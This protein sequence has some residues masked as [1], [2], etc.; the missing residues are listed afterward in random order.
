MQMKTKNYLRFFQLST[1]ALLLGVSSQLW[2][3]NVTSEV[4]VGK[5]KVELFRNGKKVVPATVFAAGDTLI[6]FASPAND[7]SLSFLMIGE[8]IYY[9]SPILVEVRSNITI[10]AGFEA[11]Q[12]LFKETFGTAQAFVTQL[13]GGESAGAYA[14]YDTP[15]ST[16]TISTINGQ[17]SNSKI[18]NYA[19]NTNDP[20]YNPE[21][22]NNPNTTHVYLQASNLAIQF[23]AGKFLV[24]DNIQIKFR[25]APVRANE[26]N[27]YYNYEGLQVKLNNTAFT[28]LEY[29]NS[30]KMHLFW[31]N[32]DNSEDPE[33]TGI[34]NS[35]T[36]LAPF[37]V[38]PVP[39]NYTSI[40]S[41]MITQSQQSTP[42]NNRCRIDDIIVIADGDPSN[43]KQVSIPTV[44]A[45]VTQLD[46]EFRGSLNIGDIITIYNVTGSV[47]KSQLV[48]SDRVLIPTYDL[49]P[50]VYVASVKDKQGDVNSF[51]IILN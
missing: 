29:G 2:A 26:S 10:Q 9:S 51:K 31:N 23:A 1:L 37:V 33:S 49:P 6:V 40:S 7:E 3:I 28:G 41:L 11:K 47:V 18:H 50:G 4:L 22:E 16:A 48:N 39:E 8:N 27:N 45:V 19:R 17:T 43:V 25:H 14:G 12:I 36:Y 34:G 5:G 21:N 38:I 13:G 32:N 24:G 44:F 15:A 42:F 35:T 46:V 20:A 30:V